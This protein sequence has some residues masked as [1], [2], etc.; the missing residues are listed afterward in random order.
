[1]VV[2]FRS[3]HN[4]TGGFKVFRLRFSFFPLDSGFRQEPFVFC[5]EIKKEGSP[6]LIYLPLGSLRLNLCFGSLLSAGRLRSHVQL[7][8]SRSSLSSSRV[9]YLSPYSS[10]INPQCSHLI[11]RCRKGCEK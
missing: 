1:M 11:C 8:K 9:I 7:Y 2:R 6:S 4:T 3:S 5:I 10:A